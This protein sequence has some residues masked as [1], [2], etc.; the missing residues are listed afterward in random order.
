LPHTVS[1]CVSRTAVPF[2][3]RTLGEQD[4][5]FQNV[6]WVNKIGISKT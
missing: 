2:R 5:Y 6:P 3:K 1:E 4:R